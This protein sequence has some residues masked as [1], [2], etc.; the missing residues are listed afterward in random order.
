MESLEIFPN[1]PS[2]ITEILRTKCINV[3]KTVFSIVQVSFN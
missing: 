2:I 3:N 1:Q